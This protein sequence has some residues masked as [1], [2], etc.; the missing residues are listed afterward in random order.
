MTAAEKEY[1]GALFSLASDEGLLD[2][3]FEGLETVKKAFEQNPG[4]LRLVENPAVK[5]DERLRLLDEALRGGV[6]PYVLNFVKIL[7]E[8]RLL[9]SLNGCCEEYRNSLYEARGI[10]PVTAWSAAPLS[11]A[12]QKALTD[13]LAKTTGKTSLLTCRV[14]AALLGGVRL[15]YAGRELD[16]TVQGRLAKLREA[17]MD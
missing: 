12:Q 14:D 1:G 15:T 3:V 9:T 5:K 4:Y 11:A 6:H 10:L 7:C 17:L 13:K 16:G 8:R 2:E